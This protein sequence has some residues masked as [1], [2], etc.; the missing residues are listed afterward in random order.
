MFNGDERTFE[1]WEFRFLGYMLMKDL[2]RHILPAAE[3]ETAEDVEKQELAF[4]ELI[5]FLDEKSLGLVIR[6]RK[7]MDV[8]RLKYYV[9][10]TRELVNR[11]F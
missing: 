8:K 4:A 3:G 1:Q 10:I 11:E 5:Q 6:G 9:N 2:K 7:I